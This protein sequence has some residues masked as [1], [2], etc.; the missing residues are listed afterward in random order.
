MNKFYISTAI[1]YVN[2]APH[3]GHALEFVQA[4]AVARYKRLLGADVFFLTG[5]DEHGLK[6]FEKSEELQI[7]T[8][9][10]VDQ[11]AYMFKELEFKLNLSNDFFVRTSEDYHKKGAQKLWQKMFEKGDIY[12]D[13]YEGLYC[14]GC[15]SFVPEKDLDEEGNCKIHLKKPRKLAEENYFFALSKYSD[16]VKKLIEDDVVRIVPENRKKEMLNI[17]GEDGLHDVSFSRPSEALPWGVEVPNDDSQVMYVWCDALSN[18]ITA[19]GYAE[20]GE[21]F[22]KYW[23]ADVH[24]IGKDILRFHAGIWLGMLLSAE[25]ELPKSIYVH[26]FVTTEGKKMSKSLGNVIDPLDY[27]DEFGVDPLRYYLL[28]EIS[29]T[30]DGDFSRDKFI[31]VYNSELANGLG[32]LV[33]RVLTMVKRYCEDSLP[34]GELEGDLSLKERAMIVLKKYEEDFESFDLRAAAE[35]VL[36]LLSAANK[37]IDEQKPWGLAKNGEKELLE[38]VLSELLEVLKLVG[39]MLLPIIPETANKILKALGVDKIEGG[40]KFV[41][42]GMRLSKGVEVCDVLF[43]RFDG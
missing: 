32:N 17:I 18:Y 16:Q 24:L 11:N 38:A 20:D 1:A 35:D 3:F 21:N 15:E 42:G 13:K 9:E 39:E 6:I 29:S 14:I 31:D 36:E 28:R 7:P 43:P 10:M 37:M 4:D 27:V 26:G 25:L 8:Q 12:K 33:N 2:G 23:P 30:D 41:W 34:E 22:S 19:L 40:E 5:T